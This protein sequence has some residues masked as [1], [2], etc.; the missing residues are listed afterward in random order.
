MKGVIVVYYSGEIDQW[1]FSLIA[2][3]KKLVGGDYSRPVKYDGDKFE[4]NVFASNSEN[5]SDYRDI[6]MFFENYND[7]W[8]AC[9]HIITKLCKQFYPD[10]EVESV[11]EL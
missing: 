2:D 4:V 5:R 6:T 11:I 1:V 9:N 8:G 3:N 7:F 10:V